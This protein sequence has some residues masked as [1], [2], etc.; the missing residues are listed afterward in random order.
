V[1]ELEP[2]LLDAGRRLSD[3]PKFRF[4]RRKRAPT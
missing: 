1:D 3:T 2:E 4:I